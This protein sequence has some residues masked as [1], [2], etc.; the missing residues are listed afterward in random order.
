MA[1]HKDTTNSISPE[2][3]R[4]KAFRDELAIATHPHGYEAKIQ[5]RYVRIPTPSINSFS[6]ERLA[7]LAGRDTPIE[8]PEEIAEIDMLL[9]T[10]NHQRKAVARRNSTD[11]N[12]ISF[13]DLAMLMKKWGA[14]V[15][16]IIATRDVLIKHYNREI[17][18]NAQEAVLEALETPELREQIKPVDLAKISQCF[19]SVIDKAEKQTTFRF[20]REES[21]SETGGNLEKAIFEILTNDPS[22]AR[23]LLSAKQKILDGKTPDEH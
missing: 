3:V 2:N 19:A 16:N 15:Q 9:S 10:I 6:P 20:H 5:K 21:T 18:E 14:L 11:E 4:K 17:I 7:A 22:A 1:D 8:D 13:E 23:D 12:K